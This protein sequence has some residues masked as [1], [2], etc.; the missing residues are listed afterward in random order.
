MDEEKKEHHITNINESLFVS[1]RTNTDVELDK[2]APNDKPHASMVKM[3]IF[4]FQKSRHSL[5][6]ILGYL[7]A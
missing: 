2:S 1:S 7:Q 4:Q 6:N 3:F 5:Q